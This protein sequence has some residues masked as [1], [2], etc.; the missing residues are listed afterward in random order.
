MDGLKMKYFVLK[1]KGDGPHA[2]ASR[3]AMLAYAEAIKPHNRKLCDD[4]TQ[5]VIREQQS[6]ME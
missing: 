4:L 3:S 2:D 5:W 1:P 6:A